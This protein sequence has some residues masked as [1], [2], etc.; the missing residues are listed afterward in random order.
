V[1]L[2]EAGQGGGRRSAPSSLPRP[3]QHEDDSDPRSALE[4]FTIDEAA[5]VCRR[6]PATIRALVSRHQLPRRVAWITRR[7]LRQRI[8][9]LSPGTV[10]RLQL[11]TLFRQREVLGG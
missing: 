7:R 5:R 2:H 9:M 4:W 3:P 1:S 11:A 6:S 10:R 8:T